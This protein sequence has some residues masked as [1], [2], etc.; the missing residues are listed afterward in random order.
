MGWLKQGAPKP[1]VMA[2]RRKGRLGQWIG[3]MDH[4]F[5]NTAGALIETDGVR[6]LDIGLYEDFFETFC[7]AMMT[8]R[9][10]QG[11]R[12]TMAPNILADSEI[13][14]IANGSRRIVL[15]QDICG[16]AAHHH[17]PAI[18][19]HENDETVIFQHS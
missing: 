15:G 13:E 9:V 1:V 5:G 19:G 16:Q 11:T 12:D 2:A 4:L 7:L 10:Q 18:F 3:K 8:T 6:I 17:T 14:Y